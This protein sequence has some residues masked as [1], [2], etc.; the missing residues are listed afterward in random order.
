MPPPRAPPGPSR[1][2]PTP[3]S[4][5]A[6]PAPRAARLDGRSR[7]GERVGSRR[8]P[9]GEAVCVEHEQAASSPSDGG[10][11]GC[12]RPP[13]APERGGTQRAALGSTEGSGAFTATQR[14]TALCVSG[15]DPPWCA[16]VRL[17]VCVRV[18]ARLFL[19]LHGG[20]RAPSPCPRGQKCTR[21]AQY[22]RTRGD[23]RT[24]PSGD[25]CASRSPRA[26]SQAAFRSQPPHGYARCALHRTS[27][28][29]KTRAREEHPPTCLFV[30]LRTA[31]RSEGRS[32]D[33]RVPCR[34]EKAPLTSSSR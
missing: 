12:P 33:L 2:G 19:T 27:L 32:R 18:Q 30:R 25:T 9:T 14:Q 26:R 31:A 22:L 24:R 23:L 5:T 21:S 7:S 29:G 8:A 16:R 28:A 34:G 15:L 1:R 10:R 4:P 20:S 6:K 3:Q 13:P 11:D 17:R